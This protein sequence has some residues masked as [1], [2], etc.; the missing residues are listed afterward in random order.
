MLDLKKSLTS[1]LRYGIVGGVMVND[2]ATINRN[3]YRSAT[4]YL[5]SDDAHSIQLPHLDQTLTGR[6]TFVSADGSFGNMV[7]HA[8]V[9]SLT[10]FAKFF[11]GEEFVV[12]G[13][14]LQFGPRMSF[15]LS[16]NHRYPVARV[17]C[18]GFAPGA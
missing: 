7:F 16:E 17:Y 5:L 6:M 4:L 10:Q 1:G 2:Q 13:I 8:E 11:A 15:R 9:S 12:D 18:L 3:S 14:L